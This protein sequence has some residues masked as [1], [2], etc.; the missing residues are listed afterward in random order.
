MLSFKI[1][2]FLFLG[3]ISYTNIH[4]QSFFLS[5]RY[6]TLFFDSLRFSGV[7]VGDTIYDYGNEVQSS[8]AGYV[9]IL[10]EL[11]ITKIVPVDYSRFAEQE[12]YSN[13]YFNAYVEIREINRWSFFVSKKDF[14][15]VLSLSPLNGDY[16]IKFHKKIIGFA[17]CEGPMVFGDEKKSVDIGNRIIKDNDYTNQISRVSAF[18]VQYSDGSS[19]SFYQLQSY[20]KE[21]HRVQHFIVVENGKVVIWYNPS[22]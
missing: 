21:E 1:N 11:I 13:I 16:N 15:N 7:V 17:E 6:D 10:R 22:E 8:E 5:P 4:S 14:S 19:Q 3:V 20:Y 9:N 18:T 2:L 12:G